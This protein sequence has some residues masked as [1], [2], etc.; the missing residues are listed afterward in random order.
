MKAQRTKGAVLAVLTVLARITHA[1]YTGQIYIDADATGANDGSS[2]VNACNYLQDAL[3][4]AQSSPKPV[5]VRVA[6][7]IYK[8]DEGANQT[9]GNREATFQLKNGVTLKGAYAGY[10]QTHPDDRNRN[11]LACGFTA[12]PLTPKQ[13]SDPNRYPLCSYLPENLAARFPRCS[14]RS[15]HPHRSTPPSSD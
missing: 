1:A 9:P 14:L 15:K 3:A 2:W 6:A 4:V 8:P 13:A 5:E 11:Y 7:G 10:G 12:G